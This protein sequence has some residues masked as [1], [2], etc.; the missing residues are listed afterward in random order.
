MKPCQE[1]DPVFRDFR[2]SGGKPG[3][4]GLGGGEAGRAS[5]GVDWPVGSP[6][7]GSAVDPCGGL[8]SFIHS[9]IH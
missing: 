4:R 7:G 1:I 9:F 3:G 5:D 6:A 8:W 2:P